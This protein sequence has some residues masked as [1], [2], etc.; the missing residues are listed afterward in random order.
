MPKY[1]PGDRVV[2]RSDLERRK[3]YMEHDKSVSDKSVFDSVVGS[4]LYFSGKTVTIKHIVYGKYVIEELP[5]FY[6]TDEMFESSLIVVEN[7]YRDDEDKTVI[8]SSETIDLLSL[9]KGK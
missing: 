3:Y 5:G 2:V 8:S 7:V 9:Y 4:M 6:W 1:K